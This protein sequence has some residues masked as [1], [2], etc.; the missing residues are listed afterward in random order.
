[1]TLKNKKIEYFIKGLV[2]GVSIV[3]IAFLSRRTFLQAPNS[4]GFFLRKME[5]YLLVILT[6]NAHFLIKIDKLY[7]FIY[8]Y[9]VLIALL[10]FVV[11]IVNNFNG[12]S[13]AEFDRYIQPG[14]GNIYKQPVFGH[15]LPIRSDE[16][17]ASLT[18]KM[19]GSYSGFSSINPLTRGTNTPG[20]IASGGIQLDFASLRNP[21]NWGYH[22]LDY[23]HGLSWS[24]AYCWAFG[25]LL[26]FELFNILTGNKKVLSLLGMIITW[27]STFNTWWSLSSL[28][29]NAVGIM[30]LFYYVLSTNKT[31]LR[32]LLGL[33]LAVVGADFICGFYPAWQVPMGWFMLCIMIWEI[34]HIKPWTS[35]KKQDW[36]VIIF[37]VV[38][39]ITIVARFLILDLEFIQ[40]IT[41][42]SYPGSRVDY[43]SF[44]ITKAL[45]YPYNFFDPNWMFLNPSES[46]TFFSFFPFGL[47]LCI[48]IQFKQKFKNALLWSFFPSL[49]I[50]AWYCITP[51]PVWLAKLFMLDS[52]ISSRAIDV[53]I[54]INTILFFVSISEYCDKKEMNII[55]TIVISLASITPLIVYVFNNIKDFRVYILICIIFIIYVLILTRSKKE[56][57]RILLFTLAGVIML[58]NGKVNPIQVGV[59]SINTKPAY[60]EI[61]RISKEKP[62]K[63]WVGIGNI[64]IPN[65]VLASGAKTLNSVNYIPNKALWDKL[66]PSGKA[67]N[68]TNRYAH[69]LMELS[70]SEF[71][72]EI[73][74][75]DLIIIKLNKK[76]LKELGIHYVVSNNEIPDSWGDTL[77]LEYHEDNVF[78]YSVLN[79]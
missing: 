28:F 46:G 42:T 1:M 9:R 48:V 3:L 65:F 60:Y 52:G 39:M 23:E 10:F 64:V 26:Y 40:S 13:V 74:Q 63:L 34:Y 2:V 32:A 43:G 20:L 79:I 58:T 57:T 29:M 7:E 76:K 4:W 22:L 54:F 33:A 75:A 17:L 37:C 49:V 56:I 66:D 59:K 25:P 18:Q 55:G 31:L 69:I 45:T 36:I 72:Y 35:F 61:N 24:W 5:I 41:K 62:E 6:I 44:S 38:F 70:D 67:W 73:P 14:L 15:S 53:F 12:S 30:V 68:D 21:G 77:K 8:K 78:I 71:T 27:F 51:M 11:I 16:W 19:S 50:L 47:I